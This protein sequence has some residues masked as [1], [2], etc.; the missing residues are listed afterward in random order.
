M[1]WG[2]KRSGETGDGKVIEG[3][4]GDGGGERGRLKNV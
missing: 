4:R 1:G 2:K 3:V